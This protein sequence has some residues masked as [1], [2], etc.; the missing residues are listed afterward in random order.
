MFAA[1][2]FVV[3]VSLAAECP[4]ADADPPEDFEMLD[5]TLDTTPIYP[6]WAQIDGSSEFCTIE[7][8]DLPLDSPS[9]CFDACVAMKACKSF[10]HQEPGWDVPNP[11]NPTGFPADHVAAVSHCV[12]FDHVIDFNGPDV[13]DGPGDNTEYAGGGSY[14]YWSMGRETEP[15]L[16][17]ITF[18]VTPAVSDSAPP[19]N[20]YYTEAVVI[21]ATLSR[22]TG[23]DVAILFQISGTARR[24]QDYHTSFPA[25]NLVKLSKH[26]LSAS[27]TV[28]NK[29][30]KLTG[31]QGGVKDLTVSPVFV[32]N[33]RR[34]NHFAVEGDDFSSDPEPFTFTFRGGRRP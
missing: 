13:A 16:P 8:P 32:T 5:F 21:T 28:T 6:T 15:E 2:L 26:A 31:P 33:A 10:A 11:L 25:T 20:V 29:I 18:T 23:K 27:W 4:G 1:L 3:A 7:D 12:L 9:N 17:E 30:A 22:S 14:T 24:G 19:P 34:P